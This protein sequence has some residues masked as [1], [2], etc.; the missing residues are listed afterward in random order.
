MK[1]MTQLITD[2][3][4]GLAHTEEEV[5]WL[6][7]NYTNDHIPDYQM[8][9]W[10]M[11]VC[12]QGMTFDETKALTLAMMRSG[13]CLQLHSVGRPLI[14]KHSTG[15]VA[16]TTTLVLAPLLA[17]AGAGV[18][19]MSG[20]GL[21]FTGGTIDK[22]ESIPGFS[23]TLQEEQFLALL[24]KQGLALTAQSASIAPADGKMYALRDVTATVDSL[25]LIA[26]SVMSKKLAAGAEHIL[27]DVKVGQGAF[28]QTKEAAVELARYMVAIGLGAGRNVK[29]VLT[30]MEQPLG[31]A[32]GNALEVAEAIEILR[33][34]G[35]LR[36]RQVCLRLA[37]EALCLAGM[38]KTQDEADLQ[39]AA[40]LDSGKALE[41][42]R[43]WIL[44]QGGADIIATPTLLPRAA[45]EEEL[46]SPYSGYVQQIQARIIGE[47]SVALGA[48][49]RYKGETLDL[50][51]GLVLACEQGDFVQ[52]GQKLA[53]LHAASAEKMAAAKK[54]LVA[55]FVLSETPPLSY[56]DVLG[57]VDADGFHAEAE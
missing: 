38:A 55:A 9:A 8:S 11:A 12:W 41:C 4:A 22:L 23:A 51:A 1:S 45:L 37:A 15:G 47:A 29:A 48:G 56:P 7:E 17:A 34:R 25:P 39:L 33:G 54:M 31:L 19:K 35:P 46:P 18:A 28:M 13:T 53:T 24:Q 40:L 52:K 57:W 30:S 20:R 14:D 49:R 6:V 2:K 16:D 42:F 43:Q 5:Q 32:V 3:K 36:L 27:L 10:L 44:S 21:G 26:A 50:A